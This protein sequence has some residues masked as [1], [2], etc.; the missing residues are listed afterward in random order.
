[1]SEQCTQHWLSHSKPTMPFVLPI[2]T[3]HREVHR[4]RGVVD[5]FGSFSLGDETIH[6]VCIRNLHHARSNRPV[7]PAHWWFRLREG[8]TN[9][10]IRP[11]DEV[12]FTAKVQRCTKGC[13]PSG[14]LNLQSYNSRRKVIGLSH[15]VRD[16]VITFRSYSRPARPARLEKM[17][18]E[19]DTLRKQLSN[20]Q[21]VRSLWLL[22]ESPKLPELRLPGPLLHDWDRQNAEA[23][24]S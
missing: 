19:I 3:L 22:N 16:V 23:I 20:G 4:F 7:L 10:G 14:L 21:Q 11:G 2:Y 12:L 6:T 15:K 18:V 13:D 17:Q 8:W 24:L 5:R 9:A 1:M